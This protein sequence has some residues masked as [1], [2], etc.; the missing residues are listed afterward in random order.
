MSQNP[1]FTT[2]VEWAGSRWPLGVLHQPPCKTV[3]LVTPNIFAARQ[4]SFFLARNAIVRPFHY[5]YLHLNYQ[6]YVCSWPCGHCYIKQTSKHRCYQWSV[7]KISIAYIL[8]RF[9]RTNRAGLGV[10][11]FSFAFSIC[12]IAC[13]ACVHI[14]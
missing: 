6:K 12:A 4:M 1:R 8:P 2:A 10:L 5:L 11:C 7:N 3:C 13:L 9:L 14:I